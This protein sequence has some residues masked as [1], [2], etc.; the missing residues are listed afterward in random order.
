MEQVEQMLLIIQTITNNTFNIATDL[1]A[2]TAPA[3]VNQNIGL[4]YSFGTNQTISNIR[5]TF[6]EME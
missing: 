5:L 6:L 4:H 2:V 3:D 1:N